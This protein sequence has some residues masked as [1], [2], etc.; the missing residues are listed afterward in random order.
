M[1]GTLRVEFEESSTWRSGQTDFY[2]RISSVTETF[3]ATAVSQLADQGKIGLDDPI[4]KYLEGVP[5][6]HNITVR[7]LATMRSGLADYTKVDGFEQAILTGIQAA[8]IPVRRWPPRS[9]R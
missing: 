4:A 5:N 7:Q 1:A 2:S 9:P 8:G 3:T 6:G